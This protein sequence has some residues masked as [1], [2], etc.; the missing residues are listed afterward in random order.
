MIQFYAPEIEE[1]CVLPP[2]ESIHCIRVLRKRVGESISVVD[3]KG[4]RFECKIEDTNLKG[5]RLEIISK[6]EEVRQ[7][8]LRITLAVAPTKNSDRISWLV[9]KATEIGIER[10]VFLKCDHSERKNV[11]IERLRKNAISAMNQSLKAIVPQLIDMMTVNDFILA[12][13]SRQNVYGYCESG[14]KRERFVDVF[15]PMDTISICIGPEGDFS[16]KEVELM[17]NAGFKAVTFG[18]ERLRTETAALY[19]VCGAH[20]LFDKYNV[21]I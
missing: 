8:G 11:N 1:K 15:K 2:D 18:D 14:V 10:I 13:Y 9:E 3:G 12:E 19:G 7:E 21:N 6:E 16:P 5:V 17:K 4:K 20:I